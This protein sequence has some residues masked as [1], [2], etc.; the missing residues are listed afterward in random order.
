MTDRPVAFTIAAFTNLCLKKKRYPFFKGKENYMH[1]FF[2]KMEKEYP[3]E[4]EHTFFN[5]GYSNK[6]EKEMFN[7]ENSRL[8]YSWGIDHEPYEADKGMLLIYKK[9]NSDDKNIF[10][11]IGKKFYDEL[12]CDRNGRLG[13]HT[14]IRKGYYK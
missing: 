5:D 12:G 10:D 6:L 13:R 1:P 8:V 7:L 4:F 2:R 14:K 11:K 3:K 9:M